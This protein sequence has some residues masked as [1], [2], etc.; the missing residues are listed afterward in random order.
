MNSS[1]PVKPRCL[2]FAGSS[3]TRPK[4]VLYG[5][6]TGRGFATAQGWLYS[7]EIRTKR[8]V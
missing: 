7:G 1:S 4:I 5:I 3:E 6:T 8:M 2:A